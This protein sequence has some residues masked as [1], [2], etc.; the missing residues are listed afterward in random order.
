MNFKALDF[1]ASASPHSPEKAS[2]ESWQTPVLPKARNA[3][4]ILTWAKETSHTSTSGGLH[5]GSQ[6]SIGE[7]SLELKCKPQCLIL[8]YSF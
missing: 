4:K 6:E 3:I 5:R 8:I 7:N 2:W 1:A